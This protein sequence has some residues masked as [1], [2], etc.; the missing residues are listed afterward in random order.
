MAGSTFRPIARGAAVCA[1]FAIAIAFAL[2]AAAPAEAG[3]AASG[4]LFFYPCTDCHPVTLD[5]SGAPVGDLPGDFAGHEIVLESHDVLGEGSAA[6]KACHDDPAN[7]PGM[8]TLVDGTLIDI[9]EA[10]RLC[11]Q[12]H[13][14][15]YA[16][17]EAGAHGRNQPS[18]TSAGCHD[19][20]TPSYIY[21]EPLLPFVGAGFQFRAVSDREPFTPLPPPAPEPA[22]HTPAWFALLAAL[23]V[24]LAGAQVFRLARGR[25]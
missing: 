25:R 16:E 15:K 18:C 13:S 8:L 6:C 2:A 3:R 11:H 17:W 10:P 14:D 5:S 9:K 12:C 19:P 21:A 20:H 22:V 4:E 1:A 7:D 24:V 23:G